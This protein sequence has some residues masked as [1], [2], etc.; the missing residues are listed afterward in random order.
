MHHLETPDI[1]PTQSQPSPDYP[2]SV[3]PEGEP[4]DWTPAADDE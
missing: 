2:N 4:D 3:G 1:D